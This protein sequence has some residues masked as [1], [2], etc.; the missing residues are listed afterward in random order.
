[1]HLTI[2]RAR[3]REAIR[4]RVTDTDGDPLVVS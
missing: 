1:M 4:F 3:R 2:W